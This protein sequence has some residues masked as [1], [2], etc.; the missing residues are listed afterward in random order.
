MP[1]FVVSA[2]STCV[3]TSLDRSAF[4]SHGLLK[5]GRLWLHI[6]T[7]CMIT[8]WTGPLFQPQGGPAP[9]TAL[10]SSRYRHLLWKVLQLK[11]YH[12][13]HSGLLTFLS[14]PTESSLGHLLL[15]A[16][17]HMATVSIPHR[18]GFHDTRATTNFCSCRKKSVLYKQSC[19]A[20][21]ESK[22]L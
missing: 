1:Y 2:S 9:A 5:Q 21:S 19:E 14:V 6:H 18:V 16:A 15:A 8:E 10:T 7:D 20:C 3:Y 12:G 13:N 11:F 22:L 4:C 17:K